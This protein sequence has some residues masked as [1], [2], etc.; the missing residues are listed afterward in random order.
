VYKGEEI[1]RLAQN[2]LFNKAC[3]LQTTQ[4]AKYL[5]YRFGEDG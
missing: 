2:K 3:Q 1:F 5:K 4:L